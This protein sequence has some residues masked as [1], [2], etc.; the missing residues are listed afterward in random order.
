MSFTKKQ[1]AAIAAM[2]SLL[3]RFAVLDLSIYVDGTMSI[4]RGEI[5]M[6]NGYVKQEGVEWVNIATPNLN[7]EAGGW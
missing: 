7:L 5:E 6:D 1:Q 2:E 3:K 4:R